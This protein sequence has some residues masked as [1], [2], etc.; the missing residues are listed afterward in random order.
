MRI[1][2]FLG[3][4]LEAGVIFLS[5]GFIYGGIEV[6]YRGNTHPS[7]F[8]LGGLSLLW[9]GGLNRFYNKKPPILLQMLIG[10]GIITLGEFLCGLVV[11]LR[12]NLKVWDY[13]NLPFNIM[14]QV[15][16]LF[17]LAWVALS[18]PAII[19]EDFLR[20]GMETDRESL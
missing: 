5:G 17:T 16:L 12:L 19:V 10:G 15:C 11:N 14:G 20:K 4:L 7:M 3:E 6:L 13:S 18:Y 8:L 1:K 2:S 9:V